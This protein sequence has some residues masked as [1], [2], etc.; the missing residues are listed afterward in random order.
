MA[1]RYPPSIRIIVQE[2]N[3]KKLKV[4]E[5]FLITY[6][7]GSLGREGSHDVIIPDINCSKYHMKFNY[8]ENSSEYKCVDLGSRNGTLINGKRMSNAKQESEPMSLIHGTTLQIGQTKL[9][10]HIHDGHTTCGHCEP[11]LI[12]I[13][14]TTS[15]TTTSVIEPIAS[16]IESNKIGSAAEEHKRQLK[17]LKKRYGLEEERKFISSFHFFSITKFENLLYFSEYIETRGGV[18]NDR[19]A[20]RR[21]KVGSSCEFEKTKTASLDS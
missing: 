11:G 1:K 5:L 8:D 16:T 21:Q 10:C 17:N 15:T 14:T 19:A 12:Q 9:L 3:V 6:K 13:T 7:G 4:G 18:Q 2:T 20:Q